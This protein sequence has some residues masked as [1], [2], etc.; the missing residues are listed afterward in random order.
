MASMNSI[1]R[2][3]REIHRRSVWQV[4]GIYLMGSW[5]ALQVVDGVT[6]NAGLPDWVPPFA[7]VLLIIG[8]PVVLAT[9]FVQEGMSG[10]DEEDAREEG[11][12]ADHS[13]SGTLSGNGA[14]TSPGPS[15]DAVGAR[16]LFTWRNAI[17]GGAGAFTLLGVAV[18][19]YFVMRATGIGPVASLAA[20][21]IFEEREPVV[22]ADFTATSVDPG[23][24]RLVMEALRVDLVESSAL[25]VV[26]ESYISEALQRMGRPDTST[27]TPEVARE[28]AQRDGFKA[29]I[30]GEVG[31]LGSGFVLTASLVEAR[32]GSDLAA[33]REAVADEAGLL[34]AIDKLSERIRE[35]AGES[36]RDIRGGE[37]LENVTT[38]SLEALRAYTDAQVLSYKGRESEAIALLQSALELDPEFGMAWRKLAVL[39]GNTGADPGRRREAATRA[40]ELRDRMGDVERL[41]AEAFYFTY[42]DVQEQRARQ[43]YEQVLAVAP[44]DPTALNNLAIG[45]NRTEPDRAIQLLERAVNGSAATA[46][47]HTNLIQYYWNGHRDDDAMALIQRVGERYPASQRGQILTL[48]LE[49]LQGHL[50]VSHDGRAEAVAGGSL[51]P[52]QRLDGEIQM[53]MDD[54]GLGRLEEGR[55]HIKAALEL[56][57]AAQEDPW[58]ADAVTAWAYAEA[59]VGSP[60]AARRYLQQFAALGAPQTLDSDG[61]MTAFSVTVLA[62]TGDTPGAERALAVWESAVP[63]AQ[64]SDLMR[65]AM[66][67]GRWGVALGKG[68]AEAA[69][70]AMDFIQNDFERCGDLRCWGWWD[71]GRALEA[72]GRDDEA[73]AMYRKHLEGLAVSEVR[74]NPVQTVDALWRLANLAEKAGDR[75]EAADAYG[76][77]AELLKDAD[78]ELQPR[79]RTAREKAEALAG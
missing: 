63:Q 20:Q 53:A 48:N 57:D 16:G 69:L 21:G 73:R 70:E 36:L 26:P 10:R 7:L 62:L 49:S 75:A 23:L 50:Q 29:V 74:W 46:V 12:A 40:Y 35:K 72:A 6:E 60:E 33:F 44:D 76:R 17:L 47:A 11:I 59:V 52:S 5:G 68:D 4:L 77:Y 45:I 42:V 13:P 41:L 54:A 65:A 9:A 27:V 51:A 32:S 3:I 30:R 67:W 43:A 31:A 56:A 2:F 66:A 8:L 15:A 58:A 22:L 28:I 55:S 71:R 61:W 34:K 38:S 39:L 24:A 78:A 25:T 79:V 14:E 1:R 64:R 19:G 37:S 18:A